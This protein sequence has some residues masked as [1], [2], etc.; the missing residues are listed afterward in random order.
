MVKLIAIRKPDGSLKWLPATRARA[1]VVSL[2][3]NDY[4]PTGRTVTES[5]TINQGLST[6]ATVDREGVLYERKGKDDE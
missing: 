2:G 5:V 6:E 4:F 3:E 1:R